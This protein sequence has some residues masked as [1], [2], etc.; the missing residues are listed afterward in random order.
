MAVD[1]RVVETR[2]DLKRFVMFPFNLYK[3]TQQWVP[4]LV[5]DE[6][7][8]LRMDKNPA[9]E[10]CRGRYW[11]ACRNGKIVGRL[12]GIINDKYVETW[13]NRYARFGWFDTID[14]P[15]V[16]SALF[17][18]FEEWVRQEGM[19][20]IHGPLGFTDLDAEGLL[21]EGFDETGTLFDPYTY[22]YYPQHIEA[23]GYRK[24][25]DYVEYQIQTPTEIPAKA[26]RVG[27]LV[28][29]RYGLHLVPATRAR[30][31]LPYA[32]QVFDL[33][34]QAYAHL[35]GIVEMTKKQIDAYV[36]QYFGFIDPRFNK[37]VV[38]ADDKVVA[39]GL[40]L[41]GL[42]EALKKSGGRFLPFGFIP[43]LRA[44]R[45]PKSL[46]MALIAV[47]P[48]LAGRGIPAV[49]FAE[50]TRAA[51]EN[52]IIYAE[53]SRELED[54]IQ[55]RSLWKNYDARQH[56]RRRIYLKEL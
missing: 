40:V 38:D 36:D 37:I 11:L 34:N 53:T 35:Y 14:D 1:V 22:D 39:F 28:L 7:R 20:G 23:L 54:N 29:K 25:T 56:R 44:L 27:E 17:G 31:L 47:R 46:Q 50:V 32:H 45:N 15:E 55:M 21:V 24:D 51:I 42:S 33:I 4:P 49:I 13:G 26:L 8:T 30:Q 2:R 19:T 10:F 12:A 9:Y 43:L 48:D 52:G 5:A 16:S 18:T 6:I 41:P 3:G